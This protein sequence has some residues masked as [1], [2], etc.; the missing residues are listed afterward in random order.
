MVRGFRNRISKV[1]ASIALLSLEMLITLGLF[2]I[3]LIA[4][5]YM[6][7][8][9][10]ISGNNDF[11]QRVFDALE[12]Y[13]N[14][15]NNNFM[16]LITYLGTHHFLIPANLILIA[17]FLFIRK[18]KWYSL[19]V[20]AIALSSV[21]L[22]YILK[23]LFGRERPLI[24]LLNEA[25]GLSFPSGHALMSVTFYGL[26]MYLTWDNIKNKAIKW[27]LLILLTLLI[28][29]IGFS[30]IYLRVHYT[31]DVIAGFSM[32]FIWLV[33]AIY[34]SKRLER[35]SKQKLNPVVKEP[36]KEMNSNVAI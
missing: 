27:T 7:K 26:L 3:A 12:P 13:V 28:I 32:G 8:K 6:V 20:P 30:R 15:A 25:R 29:L 5:I 4:F 2:F 35:Y 36:E 1:W 16:L 21:L 18:H 34:T 14:E 24:P 33:I 17:Y 9:V 23:N 19:K 22:M 10:F 31:S 11:D